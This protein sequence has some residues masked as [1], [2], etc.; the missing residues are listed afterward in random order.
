MSWRPR[1]DGCAGAG[2]H[3]A[4]PVSA[5]RTGGTR[6]AGPVDPGPTVPSRGTERGPER[7]RPA[8]SRPGHRRLACRYRIPRA[9]PVRPEEVVM[10][11]P[12]TFD[13]RGLAVL[14]LSE[15]LQRL[16]VT[17]LGRLAFVQSGSVVIVPVNYVLDGMTVMLRSTL[18]T[19]LQVAED[20]R[21]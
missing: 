9:P 6:V 20:S 3:P 16:R 18:G 15:C 21:P 1:G 13:H 7:C 17:S 14:T 10:P 12:E 11:L 5:R 4:V 8:L 19:K 2:A